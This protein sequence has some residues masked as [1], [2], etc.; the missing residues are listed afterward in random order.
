MRRMA[1]AMAAI[2]AA[3]LVLGACASTDRTDG[4]APPATAAPKVGGS[5]TYALDADPNGFSPTR[6]AWDTAGLLVAMAIYDPWAAFDASGEVRPYLAERFAHSD[7]YR[8]WTL[9]LR[10]GVVFSDGTALTAD[11][12]KATLDALRNSAVTGFPLG[13]IDTVAAPDPATVVITMK[14]PWAS[15]LAIL[16]GQV[17]VV[18]LPSLLESADGSTRP[19]GTGPFRLTSW[20]IDEATE[21]V[22]NERYW[23]PGLPRLDK[24]DFVVV[25]DGRDRVAKL[26]NG[27]IDVA[28]V[29]QAADVAA[30][31]GLV[32]QG[33]DVVHDGGAAEATMIMLNN[34][35]PPFDDPLMRQAAAAA[36]D[37]PALAKVGGWPADR[38]ANGPFMRSS[39]WYRSTS[40]PAHDADR[41]RTLVQQYEATHG[42]VEVRLAGSYAPDLVQLIAQQW[43]DAG[44]STTVELQDAKKFPLTLVTGR[45]DAAYVY[46]FGAPDP[47]MLRYFWS[48]ETVRPVGGIS[49][50]LARYQDAETDAALDAGRAS[51]DPAARQAAYATVQR[52]FAEQL[53]FIW[54]Y[55]VQWTFGSRAGVHD[56]RNVTLPD[57]SPAMPYVVGVHNL[58][59]TWRD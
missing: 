53:P 50:N 5:L 38:L 33:V 22:R 28:G 14:Q 59:E 13:N 56:A 15:F 49:I 26:A 21:V 3:A 41:A 45:Y 9:T 55:H 47:D 35:Q 30:M 11:A 46:Y 58:T 39:P 54:L 52:R 27:D 32:G 36:T 6:N 19:V 7:D 57:G 16:T 25:P 44:I 51:A 42:P 8:T 2:V 23:R 18:V 43:N 20:E 17:G 24:V 34:A 29:A 12:A 48:S 40:Y 10:T 31:D 1:M 4:A 37:I